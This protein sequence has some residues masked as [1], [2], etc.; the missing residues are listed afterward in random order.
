MSRDRTQRARKAQQMSFSAIFAFH[1]GNS[2]QTRRMLLTRRCQRR[3]GGSPHY[4]FLSVFEFSSEG[5]APGSL[6]LWSHGKNPYR[7]LIGFRGFHYRCFIGV[8]SVF[9]RIFIGVLSVAYRF[10]RPRDRATCE[11]GLRHLKEALARVQSA[12]RRGSATRAGEPG[13]KAVKEHKERREGGTIRP[14]AVC[15]A[16][17][18]K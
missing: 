3:T 17:D 16:N 6:I 11:M 5:V 1:C 15:C 14:A 13:G 10:C 12:T 9:Y 8:L 4:R 7:F 2:R 18:G